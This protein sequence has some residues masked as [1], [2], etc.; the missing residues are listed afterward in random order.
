[1]YNDKRE[2]FHL[3][4]VIILNVGFILLTFT[5]WLIFAKI[6]IFIAFL[7]QLALGI[8]NVHKAEE[9]REQS[10]ELNEIKNKAPKLPGSHYKNDNH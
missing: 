5:L 6:G 7:I 2:N 4:L 8:W 9:F 10:K 3:N 1:M